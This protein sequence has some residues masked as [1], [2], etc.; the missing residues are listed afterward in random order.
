[1]TQ[2]SRTNGA[3]RARTESLAHERLVSAGVRAT[4]A[5]SRIRRFAERVSEEMDEVTAPHG[6][7][8]TNLDDEDSL[9]TTIE[10]TIAQ[11][12]IV[13]DDISRNAKG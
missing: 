3:R 5:Y 12:R 7:Q 6:V 2:R 1:M 4:D 8:V 11:V 13:D 10:K 9:V